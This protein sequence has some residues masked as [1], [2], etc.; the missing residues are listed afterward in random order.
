MPHTLEEL[1]TLSAIPLES[2]DRDSLVNIKEIL[3]EE[4][5]PHLGRVFS[6]VK[7]LKNPYCY[8]IDDTVIKIHHANRHESLVDRACVFLDSQ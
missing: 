1:E 6:F 7:Q 3:M 2:V 4:S 5:L 8:K